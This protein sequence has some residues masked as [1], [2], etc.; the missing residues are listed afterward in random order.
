[1]KRSSLLLGVAVS[2]LSVGAFAAPKETPAATKPT[3][4]T[5]AKKPAK[6]ATKPTET[7]K[8]KMN[9]SGN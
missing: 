3:T 7:Q 5:P 8:P 6:K 2:L 1:M 9:R 4:T